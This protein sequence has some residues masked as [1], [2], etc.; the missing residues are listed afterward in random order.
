MAIIYPQTERNVA[1]D[2]R[3]RKALLKPRLSSNVLMLAEKYTLKLVE[4]FLKARGKL[5]KQKQ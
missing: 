4:S 1:R 3:K 5:T 2:I